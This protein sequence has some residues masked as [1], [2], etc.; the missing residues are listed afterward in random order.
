MNNF[1]FDR[2][3]KLVARFDDPHHAEH[4][5]KQANMMLYKHNLRWVD[6]IN[7]KMIVEPKSPSVTHSGVVS[8]LHSIFDKV[9][10]YASELS[11]NV[12]QVHQKSDDSSQLVRLKNIRYNQI[13]PTVHSLLVD[14]DFVYSN[15]QKQNMIIVDRE[16]LSLAAKNS[17]C[18]YDNIYKV[19][20]IGNSLRIIKE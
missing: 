6:V 12:H 15:E 3:L 13:T 18:L 11:E 17:N 2:F 20:I 9:K 4:A 10:T 19:N 14:I 5:L 7:E 16:L 8:T 1:S